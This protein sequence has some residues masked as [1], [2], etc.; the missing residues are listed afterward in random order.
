LLKRRQQ[1]RQSAR[2]VGV[3]WTRW[4]YVYLRTDEL[5]PEAAPPPQQWVLVL[6]PLPPPLQQ[7]PLPA[8]LLAP[9]LLP[10]KP[11]RTPRFYGEPALAAVVPSWRAVCPPDTPR[12]LRTAWMAVVRCV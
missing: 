2:G 4:S 7:R 3:H 9:L 1:Q 8:L 6:R 11:N 10:L 5:T 12:T